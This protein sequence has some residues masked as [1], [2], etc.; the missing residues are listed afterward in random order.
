MKVEVVSNPPNGWFRKS[1]HNHVRGIST[2]SVPGHI[3]ELVLSFNFTT[4][5]GG[6]VVYTRDN[7]NS[8]E[9]TKDLDW[10]KV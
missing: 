6:S 7:W 9:V 2:S 4:L 5:E 8:F 1:T 10:E 3:G